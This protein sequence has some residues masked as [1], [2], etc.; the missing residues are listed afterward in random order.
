MSQ[1]EENIHVL[2][3]T[4]NQKGGL[5]IKK[6]TSTPTFKVPQRSLLGLDKLAAVKRKEKEE[7]VKINDAESSFEISKKKLED[8]RTFRVPQSETPTYTGGVTEEARKRLL[9]RLDSTKWKER[10]V[11]ASSKDSKHRSRY[12]EKRDRHDEQRDNR[13]YEQRDNRKYR[14]SD[15]RKHPDSERSDRKSSRREF[16]FKDEPGTPDLR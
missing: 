15:R 9:N 5:I 3:G 7:N 12:D 13:K 8:S 16:R 4:S 11:Y 14:N 10:G 1:E 2:E 6:K